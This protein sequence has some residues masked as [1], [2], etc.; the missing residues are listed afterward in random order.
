MLSIV[1]KYLLDLET[2]LSKWKL[3]MSASKCNYSI[4]SNGNKKYTFDF[5]LADQAI[6]YEKHPKFFGVIFD[7]RLT[8]KPQIEEIKNKCLK[9]LNIIKII[10]QTMEIKRKSAYHNLLRAYQINNRLF[11][12][13]LLV[14][15]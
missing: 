11:I 2:W 9:R 13:L 4:F 7:A 3:S 8:F 6:P 12:Y 15:G 5:K 14:T 10:S 1:K